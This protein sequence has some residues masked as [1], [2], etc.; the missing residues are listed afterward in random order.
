MLAFQLVFLYVKNI[1][2]E[3]DDFMKKYKIIILSAIII[4]VAILLIWTI[5]R[6]ETITMRLT[7]DAY[8]NTGI[9][10]DAKFIKLYLSNDKLS[11]TILADSIAITD[12]FYDHNFQV[13]EVYYAV[14]T[15]VDT[16]GHESGY[17]NIATLDLKSPDAPKNLKFVK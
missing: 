10:S 17:S 13:G 9:N 4:T 6:S 15:A 7:W 2:R 11:W 8:D 5:T 16:A 12:T 3:G 1:H 14:A